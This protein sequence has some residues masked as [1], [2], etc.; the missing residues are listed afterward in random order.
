MHFIENKTFDE[1]AVGE[2]AVMTRVLRKEDIEL[3]ALVSGDVNPAPVDET[4]AK[5]DRFGQNVGHGMWGAALISAVLGTELP[6][7]GTIYLQQTLDF[8]HPIALGDEI[9]ARVTVRDK[10]PNKNSLTLACECTN[11][12]GEIVTSGVATV[13]AS[14]LKIR[15]PRVDLPEIRT[16]AGGARHRQLI[17]AAAKLPP[18]RTAVVHPC[19]TL[20]LEG[21]LDARQAGLIEPVLVGPRSKI[22]RAAK[23]AGVS[24]DGLTIV[25]MP[26]SHAAAAKAVELARTGEVAALMK[27]AL[28]T[29]EIMAAVV[30]HN[31]GLRTERRMSHVFALDVPTYPKTL[32]VTDAAINIAPTLEEKA[33]IVRNAVDL[34]HALGIALPKVAVLSAVE[35]VDEKIPSTL[36]AAALCKMAERGQIAGAL[37]DGPLAFDNAISKLAAT[38]KHIE[39]G[40][41]RQSR[42]SRRAQYRGGKHSRQAAHLSDRRGCGRHR[43]RRARADHPD[44]PRRQGLGARRLLRF[45]A[46]VRPVQILRTGA[47]P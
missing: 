30:A 46:P 34:C 5:T 33:D 37:L 10:D 4:Y 14:T 7:P 1:I 29:D 13:I 28:H 16:F 39:F 3:F 27:G 43:S 42:H 36:D 21:A 18:M 2:S 32:F 44:E 12:K 15:R 6:G 23:E 31:S 26:H 45:G 24:L 8:R 11:E 9:T 40:G 35:T 22:E 25:D 17:A 47:A 20:A 41:G 19:D 38:E